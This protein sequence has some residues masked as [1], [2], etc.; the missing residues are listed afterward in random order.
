MD[1]IRGTIALKTLDIMHQKVMLFEDRK[2]NKHHDRSRLLPRVS[3]QAI[4]QSGRM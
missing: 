1:K 2:Q 3:L 4:V